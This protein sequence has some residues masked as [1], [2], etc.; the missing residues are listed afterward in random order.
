MLQKT[1]S[2]ATS[3]WAQ[4]WDIVASVTRE[5]SGVAYVSLGAPEEQLAWGQLTGASGSIDETTTSELEV[6]WT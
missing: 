5:R 6:M 1:S 4:D 2:E 3:S